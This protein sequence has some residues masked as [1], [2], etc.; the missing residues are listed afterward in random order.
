MHLLKT[1]CYIER[2]LIPFCIPP[3]EGCVWWISHSIL[4]STQM[5]QIQPLLWMPT[6]FFSL[7]QII[8][9]SAYTMSLTSS[10]P[11]SLSYSEYSTYNFHFFS[12]VNSKFCI[13]FRRWLI[14][15]LGNCS[16]GKRQKYF[17]ANWLSLKKSGQTPSKCGTAPQTGDTY[18][19][20]FIMLRNVRAMAFTFFNSLKHWVVR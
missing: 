11:H 15:S 16:Q 4:H 13:W 1:R 20:K 10:I 3:W 12:C 9:T 7:K 19:D 18:T 2:F 8:I 14:V 5:I 6:W 17:S